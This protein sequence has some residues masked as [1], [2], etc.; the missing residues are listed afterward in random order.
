MIRRY[1]ASTT[2]IFLMSQCAFADESQI[3]HTDITVTPELKIVTKMVKDDNNSDKYTNNLQYPQF[4]GKLTGNAKQFNQ[5]ILSY[6]KN[7]EDDFKRQIKANLADTNNLPA[8]LNKNGMYVNYQAN[9][10]KP[11][12]QPIISVRLDLEPY[13]AGA[14][15]PA[16]N[17]K[18]FNFELKNG[19][20]LVLNDI[21]IPN[22]KY[23]DKVADY[24]RQ[25]LK[26]KLS[27]IDEKWFTEGTAPKPENYRNWNLKPE[28]ILFTFDTY[29]VAAYVYGQ[30]DVLIPYTELAAFIPDNSPIAVCAKNA[31][32]CK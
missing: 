24:S 29:Q 5:N 19:K 16:H 31:D 27:D 25:A 14:A 7:Q 32:A 17:L 13:F 18:T 22:S 21:F 9:M 20:F 8:D 1:I 2:L 11:N 10:V 4:E 15:H 28:G 26:K 12:G 23:L 30:P 6:L 3:K